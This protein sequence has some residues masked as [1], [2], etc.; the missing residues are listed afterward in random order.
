MKT[1]K[2][3]KGF[4]MTVDD[5]DYEWLISMGNWYALNRSHPYGAKRVEKEGKSKLLLAHRLIMERVLER[6]LKHGEQVDHIDR[7]KTNNTRS[8]LRVVTAAQNKLNQTKRRDNS[9][10]FKGVFRSSNNDGR[11]KA[12]IKLGKK[13]VH[14]GVCRNAYDAAILYN[15]AAYDAYGDVALLNSAFD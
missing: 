5:C 8:N 13:A 7:N 12:Q 14:L 11:F 9:T 6:K 3:T 4:S 1:I 15:Y 10:G 2:L